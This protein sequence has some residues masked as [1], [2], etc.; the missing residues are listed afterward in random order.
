M[1][2]YI[3]T[4]YDKCTK[5]S[6]N[7]LHTFFCLNFALNVVNSKNSGMANSMDPDQ[8]APSSLIWAHTVCVCHLVNNFGVWNFRTFAKLKTGLY[9]ASFTLHWQFVVY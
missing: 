8:I 6:N 3:N 2:C 9:F 4:D 5:I 7:L 1:F